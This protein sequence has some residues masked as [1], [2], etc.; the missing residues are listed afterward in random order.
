MKRILVAFT[1][2]A[3]AACAPAPST[4][5]EAAITDLYVQ[6]QQNV[7]QRTITPIDAIPMTDDLAGLVERARAAT[8]ARGEPFIEGDIPANCQDCTSITDLVIGAQ[9]GIEQV[10]APDGHR[11]VEARFTLN[12]EDPRAVLYDMIETPDGWR[13]DNILTEGFNLRAEAQAYLDDAEAAEAAS[14]L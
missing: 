1:L 4:G 12:G 8:L 5:P 6:V 11:M 2:L 9:T 7:G 3:L 14:K 10:P 13:V